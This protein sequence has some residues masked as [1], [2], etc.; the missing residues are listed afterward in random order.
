[1]DKG[2]TVGEVHVSFMHL[3]SRLLRL[4][5]ESGWTRTEHMLLPEA[6]LY[7]E[8]LNLRSQDKM[9]HWFAKRL[10]NPLL[11]MFKEISESQFQH[12]SQKMIAYIKENN[13]KVLTLEQCAADLHYNA[14]YLSSVFKKGTGMTFSDYVADHRLSEAKKWLVDTDIPIKQIAETLGYKNSQNFIRSFRKSTS[15]TPGQYRQEKGME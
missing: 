15:M 14:N 1:M 10:L 7:Q 4:Y 3:I 13:D 8:W 9:E 5:H 6:T 11:A 2:H 12:L